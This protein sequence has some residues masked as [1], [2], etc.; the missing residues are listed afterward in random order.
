M[1]NLCS[2]RFPKLCI[3]LVKLFS[4]SESC[5][6]LLHLGF[7]IHLEERHLRLGIKKSWKIL[8][9]PAAIKCDR[10]SPAPPSGHLGALNLSWVSGPPDSSGARCHR[11]QFPSAASSHIDLHHLG[12]LPNCLNFSI[13]YTHALSFFNI[14]AH[15]SCRHYNSAHVSIFEHFHKNSVWVFQRKTSTSYLQSLF[16]WAFHMGLFTAHIGFSFWALCS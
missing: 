9:P 12:Q 15:W 7:E 13:L 6:H 5:V 16:S 10:L 3:Y 14:F 4:G 2:L 8:R 11:Q 1:S